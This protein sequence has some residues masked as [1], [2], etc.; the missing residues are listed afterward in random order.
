MSSKHRTEKRQALCSSLVLAS[1]V[2][3]TEQQCGEV[4][5]VGLVTHRHAYVVV[6]MCKYL[7]VIVFKVHEIVQFFLCF[8]TISSFMC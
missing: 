1:L 8:M 7:W 2:G 5:R 3:H 6:A 4:V